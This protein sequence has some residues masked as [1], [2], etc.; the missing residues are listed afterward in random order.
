MGQLE[1]WHI[2]VLGAL[3]SAPLMIAALKRPT[4]PLPELV[5]YEIAE[6]VQA[7]LF[8]NLPPQLTTRG[9]LRLEENGW[10]IVIEYD[11]PADLAHIPSQ[12]NGV[13]IVP[14]QVALQM[15]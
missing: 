15:S 14:E 2:L 5:P 9:G 4:A 7:R 12:R 1:P 10:V 8:E 11:D 3:L 6:V 13:R